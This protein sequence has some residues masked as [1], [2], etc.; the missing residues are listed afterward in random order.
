MIRENGRAFD[1][2]LQEGVL[3]TSLCFTLSLKK[4]LNETTRIWMLL[5]PTKPLLQT[6]TNFD[7]TLTHF[8]GGE[9]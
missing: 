3:N 6:H 4:N 1:A 9:C 5:A 8:D 7:E 2:L